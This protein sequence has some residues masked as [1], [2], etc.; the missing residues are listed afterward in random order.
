MSTQCNK[1]RYSR[2]LLVTS[3]RLPIESPQHTHILSIGD[4][5]LFAAKKSNQLKD[6][7]SVELIR[8][9]S[10]RIL[11]IARPQVL[12]KVNKTR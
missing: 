9:G 11:R 7:R 5:T 4:R 12:R 2:L 6:N 1:I 10:T 3:K 8:K